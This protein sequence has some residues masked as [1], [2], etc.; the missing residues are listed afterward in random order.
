MNIL[1]E[2]QIAVDNL[3]CWAGAN[4]RALNILAYSYRKL[5]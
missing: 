5:Q 3:K 2:K 4:L 1:Q